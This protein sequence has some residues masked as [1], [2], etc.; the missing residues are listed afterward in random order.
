MLLLWTQLKLKKWNQMVQWEVDLQILPICTVKDGLQEGF[1]PKSDPK[2][3]G[4]LIRL[5]L[6]QTIVASTRMQGYHLK[7]TQHIILSISKHKVGA[8]HIEKST[9]ITTHQC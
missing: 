4:L 1:T 9:H 7:N 2:I 3:E 5:T 8:W 6:W